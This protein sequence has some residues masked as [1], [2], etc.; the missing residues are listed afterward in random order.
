MDNTISAGA[1]ANY[2]NGKQYREEITEQEEKL[3]KD[4]N[5]VVVFG[6][7]DDLI[8]FRGAFYGE[9]GAGD[10]FYFDKEFKTIAEHNIF[11]LTEE[12]IARTNFGI[13]KF[14]AKF[15]LSNHILQEWC[16]KDIK[17]SWRISANFKHYPFNVYDGE[18]LYCIGIVFNVNDLK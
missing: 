14:N 1:L 2:L 7:S 15:N 3:A 12:H 8:E 17:T 6:A 18:D 4:S 16:P 13:Y 10:N 9:F 11:K 5:L